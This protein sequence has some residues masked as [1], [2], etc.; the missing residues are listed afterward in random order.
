M[1]KAEADIQLASK[2]S[3]QSLSFTCCF[4]SA[5]CSLRLEKTTPDDADDD[6]N[7]TVR[8][9]TFLQQIKYMSKIFQCDPHIKFERLSLILH[10]SKET[11]TNIK[12]CGVQIFVFD[13]YFI[14]TKKYNL[15]NYYAV[16]WNYL[17]KTATFCRL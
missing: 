10:N 13:M 9:I 17:K 1:R 2:S 15:Q 11:K 7:L 3:L 5:S 8:M 4:Q 12:R 16:S 6:N 14:K